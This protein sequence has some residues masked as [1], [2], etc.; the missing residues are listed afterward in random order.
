MPSFSVEPTIT[1]PEAPVEGQTE[2]TASERP[3][4]LPEKFESAEAL[5]KAYGELEAKLGAGQKVDPQEETQVDPKVVEGQAAVETVSARLDA[6]GLKLDTFQAS[7]N[8]NGKLS[9][10][11][12]QAL[13]KAGLDKAFVDAFIA[14]QEAIAAL[15][16]ENL[17][18]EIGGTAE[19]SKAQ[20]WARAN[21]P[22]AT[23]E[24]FNSYLD[25]APPDLMK[26]AAQGLYAQFK[27]S[28]GVEP[29]LV[30]GTEG[31]SRG[32]VGYRSHYEM[33]EAMKDPRYAK[34]PAYRSD[35]EEKVKLSTF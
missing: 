22:K 35:V 29:K 17:L 34:D 16:V 12:Y 23:I 10:D 4:W 1:G 2:G 32:T 33:V 5:A 30:T 21:L 15:E 24:A 11:D 9:D 8:K 27:A 7:Y 6:A 26:V 31:T 25:S 18:A 19:W 28:R 20:E 3:E 13:A 14:G